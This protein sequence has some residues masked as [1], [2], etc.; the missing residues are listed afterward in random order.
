[1]YLWILQFILSSLTKIPD[2]NRKVQ[3]FES[4]KIELVF[5]QEV[6]HLFKYC[7]S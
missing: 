5:Y 7:V 3:R 4:L 6:G 1:M 2:P